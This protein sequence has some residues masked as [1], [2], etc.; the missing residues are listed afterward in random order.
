VNG[1]DERVPIPAFPDVLRYADRPA[2][3]W[4]NGGGSTRVIAVAPDGARAGEFDWRMSVA[5]VNSGDFS[6]FPGVDRVIVLA[7]GPS[8]TLTIDGVHHP[9]APF[10]PMPFA[11]ESVVSCDVPQQCLDFNVMTRRGRCTADVDIRDAS[12]DVAPHA[13]A[14]T[15]VVPLAGSATVRSAGGRSANLQRFDAVLLEAAASVRVES[16][17]R[18]AVVR[19]TYAT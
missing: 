18:I 5:T 8:M 6:G 13:D 19:V 1:C 14:S 17:G 2:E 3:P 9:L 15:L 16:G 10:E 7:D 4:A 12:G 11:G